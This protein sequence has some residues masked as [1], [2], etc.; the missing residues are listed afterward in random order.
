MW[1]PRSYR[2]STNLGRQ[3]FRFGD[4]DLDGV[5]VVLF[6]FRKMTSYSGVLSG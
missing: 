2:Q 5:V 6:E 4:V 3:T 1:F